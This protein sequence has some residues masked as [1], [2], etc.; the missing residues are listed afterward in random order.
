MSHASMIG[1]HTSV[2]D[3]TDRRI[4]HVQRHVKWSKIE[5]L[6]SGFI[7]SILSRFVESMLK[8][9][10]ASFS[11]D[12][13]WFRGAAQSL[14]R[15]NFDIA[16]HSEVLINRLDSLKGKL[17]RLRERLLDEGTG[18]LDYGRVRIA[19]TQLI[20]SISDLFESVEEF[21]WTIKEL[22]A[23]HSSCDHSMTASSPEELANLFKKL[24]QV[25]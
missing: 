4:N 17:Q 14:W 8:R 3:L 9:M 12:T 22:E 16:E 10:A 1:P 23:N 5:A 7:A 20:A 15:E 11:D 24:T 2:M 18:N 13:I 19:K 25:A 6:A 21:K